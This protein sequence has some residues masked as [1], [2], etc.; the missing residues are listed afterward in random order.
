MLWRAEKDE[1]IIV[2][3]YTEAYRN[4]LRYY[5]CPTLKKKL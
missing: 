4:C 1:I 2:F 3:L 5:A